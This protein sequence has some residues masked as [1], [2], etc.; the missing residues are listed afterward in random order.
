MNNKSSKNLGK[1]TVQ[2]CPRRK[3]WPTKSSATPGARKCSSSSWRRRGMNWS[4]MI[5]WAN[6]I[7]VRRR[8]SSR[9]RSSTRRMRFSSPSTPSLSSNSTYSLSR[10]RTSWASSINRSRMLR[11]W[12][13]SI[14]SWRA[15][16]N[17]CRRKFL[18]ALM[19]TKSSWVPASH[20][21][22]YNTNR[23]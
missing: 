10:I 1:I 4:W 21:N 17:C 13:R 20:S 11:A 2:G 9:T 8:W 12:R 7:K 5:T 15:L 22:W 3:C 23:K 19:N 14:A 18:C 6:T 16:W